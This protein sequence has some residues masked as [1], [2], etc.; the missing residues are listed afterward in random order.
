MPEAE[1]VCDAGPLIHLDEVGLTDALHV[2][3]R[4][5]VPTPVA[6]EVRLQPRGPGTALLRQRHV[7][8]TRP[9]RDEQ[10]AADALPLRR[11]SATDRAALAMAQARDAPLLTDDLDLRDAA[12]SLEVKAVG[13]IGL[14]VRAVT[15]KTVGRADALAALDRLV[16]DSSM[17]ITRGLIERAKSAL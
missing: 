3:R 16:D 4:I 1:A 6:D 10:A 13:T 15:T 2:F 7:H 8:L 11:L 14:I 5:I 12:R 9:S 17:F